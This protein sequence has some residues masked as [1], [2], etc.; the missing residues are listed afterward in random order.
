M[1]RLRGTLTPPSAP[2][3]RGHGGRADKYLPHRFVKQQSK[4][5]TN[6]SL[7]IA[8]KGYRRWG[9]GLLLPL[10]LLLAGCHHAAQ[11][12]AG[13]RSDKAAALPVVAVS[14]VTIGTVLQ[15]SPV[16]GT[17]APLP[18]HEAKVN[19]PFAGSL[20][21]VFVQPNQNVLK[22][23]PV[24]QMS[25]QPLMGQVQQAQSTI[26]SARLQV[27]QARL[28]AVQQQATSRT[29]V[30]QAKAQLASAQATLSNANRNL[31]REQKLFTDGL[32]AKKDVDDAQLAVETA[33]ATAN[34]QQ[35]AVAAAQAA[36]LTDVVKRQD[37]A[38][39]QEQV[40]NAEGALTTA[41]SQINLASIRAPI[42]GTVATVTAN[43]GE[44]ADTT[45]TLLTIVDMSDL[46]LSVS[47]AS[48]DIR[49]VR[50]GQTVQFTT[51]SLPGRQFAGVV[52]SIGAQVDPTTGTVPVLVRIP[53]TSHL[54]KD[55]L[56]VNGQIIVAR[57]PGALLVP[58][59]AVLTDPD[60][61]KTSVV[62]I[63]S[64]G[65]AHIRQVVTGLPAGDRVE[66]K[67]GLT[68]GEQVAV[69]GQYA[70]PDGAKVS[71]QKAGAGN[72]S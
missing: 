40:R 37:I 1:R 45:T 55:D 4:L 7:A 21:G 68:A 71:V 30:A 43:S 70:L 66:V 36:T 53:N 50:P 33:S 15:T 35:Q 22:G 61:N 34:A 18:N 29:A 12:S 44:T 10:L 63:G 28:N 20:S 60:S 72:A 51:E 16:T 46:Q 17:L 64:D 32:V 11:D 6:P 42:S 27:Q 25:I 23:Q 38:V 67:K 58:K 26:A 13:N 54:L 2:L 39:A 69:S 24:A 9:E 41:R 52:Q 56:Q 14:T 49:L 47:V 65:V 8:G 5:F 48:R 57:H 31:A 19:A 3:P 62:V 59:S